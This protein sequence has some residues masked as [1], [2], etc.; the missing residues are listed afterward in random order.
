MTITIPIWAIW[1]LG[2][3]G[4]LV[5]SAVVAGLGFLS[6]IGWLMLKYWRG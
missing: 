4:A 1:T 5:A 2:I 3:I 6:Y